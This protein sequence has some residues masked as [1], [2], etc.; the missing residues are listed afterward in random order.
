[1]IGPKFNRAANSA[2]QTVVAVLMMVCLNS[3]AV[4][5]QVKTPE[6]LATAPAD[7]L[8]NVGVGLD[9]RT[10]RFKYQHSDLGHVDKRLQP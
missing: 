9:A 10:G 2:I 5:A 4:S 3:E 8:L 7:H 1:M 6:A